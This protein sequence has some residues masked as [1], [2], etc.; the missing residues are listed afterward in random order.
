MATSAM[1]MSRPAFAADAGMWLRSQ[2]WDLTFIT[3]S[4]IL[5]PIPYLAWL[6]L[7]S[8]GLNI[9]LTRNI[10]NGLVAL[11]VGGPHMYCTFRVRCSTAI[12]S[13]NARHLLVPPSPFP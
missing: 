1:R 10:V 12:L 6:G 4:V 11:A 13:P 8:L 7:N 9:D 3:L 5:V 2:R